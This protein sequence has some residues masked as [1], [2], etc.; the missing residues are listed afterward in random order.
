VQSCTVSERNG[1]APLQLTQRPAQLT[2]T[3]R[4]HRVVSLRQLGLAPN[5]RPHGLAAPAPGLA[6]EYPAALQAAAEALDSG[7]RRS[8]ERAELGR[9][10]DELWPALVRE[11]VAST[12]GELADLGPWMASSLDKFEAELSRPP[13]DQ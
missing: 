1:S 2:E 7:L 10:I 6:P 4:A 11:T 5:A 3:P 13:T 8:A 12:L 9:Q